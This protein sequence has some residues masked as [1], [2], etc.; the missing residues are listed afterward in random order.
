TF[1]VTSG[2]QNF[3]YTDN[4]GNELPKTA[5]KYNAYEEVYGR[6]KTFQL[7]TSGNPPG[8]TVTYRLKAG[9]PTDVISVDSNGLVHILNASL[10]TQMGR[11][12]V[13]AISHDPTGNYADKTIELPINIKKANQT[14]SF[15]GVTYATSG[16]GQVTPV[17]TEQDISS[18]DGGVTVNDTDY[19]IT[20]DNSISTSTAW[21][22]DGV[23]IEY[24]YNGDN[25][26]D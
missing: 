6:N 21:T 26:L 24:N 17:I 5:N 4:A 19:Y 23:N 12:I 1:T 16:S 3:I 25:G 15:A 10:N 11:V 9:S 14:I 2:S 20:I 7:Y 22:N 8:S 13:E 18:N